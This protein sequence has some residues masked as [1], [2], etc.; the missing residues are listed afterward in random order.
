MLYVISGPSGCGKST[1]IRRLLNEM[2]P[3]LRFS[4][5]HTTR[6]RRSMELHGKDYYFV[7]EEE[8]QNMIREN[9]FLEWAVVHGLHYGTSRKEIESKLDQGDLLLDIDIQGARQ[10][11]AVHPQAVFVFVVPSHPKE[12]RRR[13]ELRGSNTPESIRERLAAARKEVEAFEE[14]DYIVVNDFLERAVQ[15]IRSIIVSGKCRRGSRLEEMSSILS[16]Y[17]LEADS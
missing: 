14:F 6:P 5:S 8:F 16:H 17:R 1:L 3:A 4:V 11:R 13:L 2:K 12:L 7:S 10:I 9:A 15:E